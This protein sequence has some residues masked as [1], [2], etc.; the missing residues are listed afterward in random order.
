MT[1]YYKSFSEFTAD[2]DYRTERVTGTTQGVIIDTQTRQDL[3]RWE[4][5]DTNGAVK[6]NWS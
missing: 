5:C 3:G 6:V 2:V 1:Q 4:Y